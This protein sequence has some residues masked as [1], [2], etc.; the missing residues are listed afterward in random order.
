MQARGQLL[1]VDR[2]ALLANVLE[3]VAQA[4]LAGDRVRSALGELHLREQVALLVLRQIGE[5]ELAHR[6][7]IRRQ[8]RSG[9]QPEVDLALSA[10]EA[11]GAIYVEDLRAVERGQVDGV[12]G[13]VGQLLHIWPRV[14][15][16]PG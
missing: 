10:A 5:Q 1:I 11:T 13:A 7:A 12:G 14:L 16:Q 6:G 2:K 8:T 15:A 4:F 9:R 3:L